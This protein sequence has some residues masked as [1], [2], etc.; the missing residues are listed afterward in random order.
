MRLKNIMY[1]VCQIANGWNRIRHA[2]VEAF[3]YLKIKAMKMLL[4]HK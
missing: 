4:L 1:A 2:A 3:V